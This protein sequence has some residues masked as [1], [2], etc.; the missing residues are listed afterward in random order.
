M[1]LS[2]QKW[3][4]LPVIL[5]KVGFLSHPQTAY[6]SYLTPP[7]SLNHS[8]LTMAANLGLTHHNGHHGL[9][10]SPQN[11]QNMVNSL[12]QMRLTPPQQQQQ[13]C[14]Q[15]TQ[16]APQSSAIPITSPN[17]LSVSSPDSIGPGSPNSISGKE[18]LSSDT[19]NPGNNNE[20]GNVE[21]GTNALN[22]TINTSTDL[23]TNSIAT[24]RIKAKEHI[25][26]INKGLTIV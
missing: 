6:P 12:P 10:I 19:N 8:N 2:T 4:N 17:H 22:M 7:L 3:L 24:L 25:E 20:L 1:F 18:K 16:L 9:R 26:N 21:N 15:Q 23:R 5:F 13:H 14:P 11:M